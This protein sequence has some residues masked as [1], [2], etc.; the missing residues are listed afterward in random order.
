M[1][2]EERKIKG[3]DDVTLD[4]VFEEEDAELHDKLAKVAENRSKV[5]QELIDEIF[6]V[7]NLIKN[8][9]L[10]TKNKN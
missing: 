10:I 9:E 4:I 1:K 8:Y 2:I 5:M 6:T 3:S 7:E